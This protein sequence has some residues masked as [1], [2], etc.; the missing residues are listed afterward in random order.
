LKKKYILT[1]ISTDPILDLYTL[2]KTTVY[3]RRFYGTSSINLD[4]GIAATNIRIDRIQYH[5]K[6]LARQSCTYF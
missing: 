2:S 4:M 6:G 1:K 5:F 3:T